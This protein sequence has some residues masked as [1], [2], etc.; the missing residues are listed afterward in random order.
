MATAH[1]IHGYLGAGKTTLAQRLEHEVGAVRFTPDEWMGRLFG[2]NP[3]AAIFQEKA[4]AILEIMEPLWLRCLTLGV[5]V[6][7]D[8][9]FWRRSE[10]D[11][12]RHLAGE[13][14]ANTLLYALSCE[15]EEALRRVSV[16][17]ADKP[18]RLFIAPETF[19]LLK[20]RFEA[21]EPDET[22]IFATSSLTG[23]T[24]RG[25]GLVPV[26]RGGARPARTPSV[27]AAP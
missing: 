26:A 9:G 14:G 10:R 2:D 27:S 6:V 20:A 13:A 24:T 1:L 22:A 25:D 4:A 18:H 19:A 8:Y 5:D 7:L 17:N 16:R 21:L 3:P 23:D 11:R 15:E 12:A